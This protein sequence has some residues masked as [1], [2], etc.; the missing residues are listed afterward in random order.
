[1]NGGVLW[2]PDFGT[3][4]VKGGGDI[5][6]YLVSNK[7]GVELTRDGDQVTSDYGLFQPGRNITDASWTANSYIGC[8]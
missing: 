5:D 2:S 8:R 7:W 4:G 3:K 6:F 1:M